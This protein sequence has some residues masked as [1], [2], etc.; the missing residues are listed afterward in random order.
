LQ[1]VVYGFAVIAGIANTVF[2]AVCL[3]I[4]GY[5]FAIA[6]WFY[7][8]VDFYIVFLYAGSAAIAFLL[9]KMF[10]ITTFVL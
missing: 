8:A 7:N 9:L 3:V 6:A 2:V 10:F 5:V 1:G 4:V